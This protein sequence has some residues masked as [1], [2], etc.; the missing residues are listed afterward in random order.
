[1][2]L[3]QVGLERL[4]TATTD[5]LGIR[6][7][8][9]INGGMTVSQRQTSTTNSSAFVVD[10]FKAEITQMDELVQTLEQSSDAPDGFGKSIKI[11]TTTPESSIAS[12]ELAT[13]L[14]LGFSLVVKLFIDQKRLIRNNQ[15]SNNVVACFLIINK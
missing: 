2:A 9:I 12:N 4:N 10:R 5:K 6:K 15:I 7:N 11:T 1:M 3:S 14:I 13:S 8:K